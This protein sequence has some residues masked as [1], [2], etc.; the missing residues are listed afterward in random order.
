MLSYKR[1]DRV[2]DLL[3]EEIVEI[4][5]RKINDPRIG[6]VTVTAVEVTADLQ[7]AKV[8]VSVLEGSADPE[9]TLQG[10]RHAAGYIRREV[11]RRLQLRRT[12]ELVFKLDESI[13]KG[14][15]VLELMK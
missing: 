4:L 2:A 7:V 1:T 9:K 14:A 10:L 13:R 5:A 11:G 12:P 8:F 15:H 3:R 6:F